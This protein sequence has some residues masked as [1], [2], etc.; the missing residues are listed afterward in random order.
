M[1]FN[2]VTTD[3]SNLI[4]LLDAY[5]EEDSYIKSALDLI[6]QYQNKINKLA[7]EFAI[8]NKLEV[9]K[10][11]L[12]SGLNSLEK[13]FSEQIA[14]MNSS[15]RS[16]TKL[17]TQIENIEFSSDS[18]NLLAKELCQSLD[19]L[20]D[21]TEEYIASKLRNK[22]DSA[23]FFKLISQL[24]NFEQQL[25]KIYCNNETLKNIGDEL[26]ETV[27]LD[28][29]EELTIFSLDIRS[30]KP[31]LDISSFTD[32]LKLIAD[33]LQ[34]LER[35]VCAS[36]NHS[37]YI[38]KIESGS[39]KAL[40]GSASVDFSIFPDLITSFANALKTWKLTPVEKEKMQA[41]T[42]KLKAETELINAQAEEQYIKNEGS[43]LAMISSQIDY[44][45]NKLSLN[46]EDPNCQEQIQKFCLPLINYLVNNPIGSFNGVSYDISKEVRLIENNSSNDNI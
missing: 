24:K 44:I 17:I 37:I 40:F 18:V 32:D 31:E 26:L 13:S 45:C 14:N 36:E 34:N 46:S 11:N 10:N 41:E 42:A 6:N 21:I 3:Y 5:S 43:K 30:Y 23:I 39:L 35:L 22:P 1:V 4:N 20:M 28:N 16:A 15:M 38:R 25:N 12:I 9:N 27:P 7:K 8:S 33:C 2:D 19:I 29:S